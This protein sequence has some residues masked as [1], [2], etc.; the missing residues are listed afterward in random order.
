[1]PKNKKL[2]KRGK[3]I[4]YN[5]ASDEVKRGLDASRKVEWGKWTKHNAATPVTASEAAMLREQGAE[6]IGTQWIEVDK[7][8][9]QRNEFEH[10]IPP[11][12]KSRLVALGDHEKAQNR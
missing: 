3:L 7:N 11:L 4:N 12:Y 5:K 8:E 2:E 6:E 9:H 10:D 1:M